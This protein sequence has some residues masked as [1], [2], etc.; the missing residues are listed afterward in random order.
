M[1]SVLERLGNAALS[2]AANRK[3]FQDIAHTRWKH[4]VVDSAAPSSMTWKEAAAIAVLMLGGNAIGKTSLWGRICSSRDPSNYYCSQSLS[5]A[6]RSEEI[7]IRMGA[8]LSTGAADAAL[9]CLAKLEENQNYLQSPSGVVLDFAGALCGEEGKHTVM[10]HL[11][12]RGSVVCEA[13]NRDLRDMENRAVVI[14]DLGERLARDRSAFF[15]KQ[16]PIDLLRLEREA[17]AQT[18]SEALAPEAASW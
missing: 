14:A 18:H 10:R 15:K 9:F 1:S 17:L 7:L 12:N 2:N 6:L 13:F 16:L 4:R 3:F 5:D 8:Y 11:N